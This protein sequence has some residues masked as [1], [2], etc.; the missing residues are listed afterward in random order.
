MAAT[1]FWAMEVPAVEHPASFEVGD[2]TSAEAGL[3]SRGLDCMKFAFG[4]PVVEPTSDA[5]Q[6]R[7]TMAIDKKT[8]RRP[9]P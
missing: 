5:I 8:S 6:A 3:D 2:A 9:H 4:N 1:S 7:R